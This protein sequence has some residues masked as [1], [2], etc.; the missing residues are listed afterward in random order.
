VYVGVLGRDRDQPVGISWVALD[1]VGWK[2][3]ECSSRHQR[4]PATVA[5]VAGEGLAQ[6]CLTV[7]QLSDLFP[8]WFVEIDSGTAEG[9]HRKAPHP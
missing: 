8:G 9:A 1:E 4:S 7:V 3:G 2:A 5:N 6:H